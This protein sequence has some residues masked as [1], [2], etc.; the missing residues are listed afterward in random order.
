V[1]G[2]EVVVAVN[3][4]GMCVDRFL[5]IYRVLG[6]LLIGSA[7]GMYYLAVWHST[8]VCGSTTLQL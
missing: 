3:H 4:E 7:G 2:H 1:G 6:L 8:K 5:L